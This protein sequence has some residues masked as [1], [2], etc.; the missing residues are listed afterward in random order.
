MNFE[1][2]FYSEIHERIFISDGE[3]VRYATT[4]NEISTES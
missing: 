3:S 1:N 4:L 2:H